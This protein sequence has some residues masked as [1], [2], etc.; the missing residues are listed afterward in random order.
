ELLALLGVVEGVLVRGPGDADGLGADRGTRGLERRHGRLHLGPLALA[1]PGQALVELVLAAE[2]AAA[3]HPA[4]V[5]DD[6]AG[7]RRADAV[8]LE[9]LPGLQTGRRGRHDEAGL[10]PRPELGFDRRDDNVDVGDAAVGDPR[11][12]AVEDPL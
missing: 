8:L 11:L 12:G 7:V 4:V 10:T 2:Q 3:R 6:L 9:L 5:E 1:G